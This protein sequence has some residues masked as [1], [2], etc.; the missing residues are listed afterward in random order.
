M[1][2][3]YRVT[4][5]GLRSVTSATLFARAIKEQFGFSDKY[6]LIEAID[7]DDDDDGVLILE[8]EKRMVQKV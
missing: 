5:G 8:S 7:V 2:K 4:F 6:V 3:Q 1:K